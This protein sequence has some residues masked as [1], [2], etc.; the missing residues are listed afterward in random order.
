V[1]A[2]ALR[3]NARDPS[4][5]RGRE[6]VAVSRTYVMDRR[7]QPRLPVNRPPV[8]LAARV[9]SVLGL[10]A[11]LFVVTSASVAEGDALADGTARNARRVTDSQEAIAS[12][13]REQPSESA[14]GCPAGMVEV[15]GQHCPELEQ[16]CLKWKDAENVNPRRCAEFAPST[17]CRVATVNK[18]F[19]IDRFEYPNK[20]GATPVVMK[21]WHEAA[22]TCKADGKR[23]CGDSEWTLACE[24]AQH[25]PYPYGTKRDSQA[26]NIDKPHPDV[27]ERA[28]ANPRT[29]DA[30]VARLWQ[31]EPS[32]ARAACVSS[33]GVHDMTGNVDEWV[34]N[35]SGTPFKSALK[36]GYWGPV[37]DRCRPKTTAH[38]EDFQF[39]QIGFRCCGDASSSAA[40]DV[41]KSPGQPSH[42]A[43]AAH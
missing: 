9:A 13:S 27:N 4:A 26:C 18:H 43:R 28:L 5:L 21:S 20:E 11:A 41:A 32:G 25:L 22:A 34:V 31:G 37:R 38:G 36:G 7:L 12:A 17:T 35:E 2:V 19:C 24:G 3:V 40:S 39:Y 16:R 8:R 23:L 30:E 29:R 33:F 1:Q 10:S 15:V 6:K 14:A 42:G